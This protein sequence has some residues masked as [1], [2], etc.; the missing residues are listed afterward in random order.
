MDDMNNILDPTLLLLSLVV[1]FVG[2]TVDSILVGKRRAKIA[3][4]ERKKYF[5][6]LTRTVTKMDEEINQRI[7]KISEEN[8]E[9]VAKLKELGIDI[10][11][12]ENNDDT[13]KLETELASLKEKRDQLR[14]QNER[15]TSQCVALN[16]ELS[17]GADLLDD[18]KQRIKQL[19]EDNKNLACQTDKRP[20]AF[21]V[22]E[23]ELDPELTD[24]LEKHQDDY[25]AEA[26]KEI[27]EK[28]LEMK[29]FDQIKNLD[30]LLSMLKRPKS[31]YEAELT[32]LDIKRK[33][34]EQRLNQTRSLYQEELSSFNESR[35]ENLF[36]ITGAR[37]LLEAL[38][39]RNDIAEKILDNLREEVKLKESEN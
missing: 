12:D 34:V 6:T 4:L 8:N 20:P 5:A 39:E 14:A 21:S 24:F 7:S 18:L 25:S 16:L 3:I 13:E 37:G 1:Y 31:N 9:L 22:R 29:A 28:L 17:D 35:I 23:N 11:C 36:K 2:Q 32:S 33:T 10:I 26:L 15:I 19:D 27:Y 30:S 38:K